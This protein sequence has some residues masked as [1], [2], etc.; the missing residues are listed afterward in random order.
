M[1]TVNN[2]AYSE[3]LEPKT[4]NDLM[5]AASDPVNSPAHYKMGSM[6][7]YQI[8]EA[9]LAGIS[10]PITAGWM[11]SVVKYISRFEHK[12]KPVQDLQK[13]EWYLKKAIERQKDLHR[14]SGVPY[15]IEDY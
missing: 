4:L 6:E 13:A 3:Q 1:I 12:G 10:D 8:I 2:V 11:A 7:T 9:V 15:P 14:V 5:E